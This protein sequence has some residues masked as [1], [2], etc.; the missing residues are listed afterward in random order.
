MA[1]EENNPA[2][3]YVT[4]TNTIGIIGT[5]VESFLDLY[6]DDR[7][8]DSTVVFV[9]SN[10]AAASSFTSEYPLFEQLSAAATKTTPA[11]TISTTVE[12][13]YLQNS[14]QLVAPL[15]SQ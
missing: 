2:V 1:M 15:P 5:L 13:R 3:S 10:S 7:A 6:D 4:Q 14:T 9:F 8:Y 11:Q 12:E